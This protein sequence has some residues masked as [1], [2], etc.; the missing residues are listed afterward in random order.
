M[1]LI[2]RNLTILC[3]IFVRNY[4][5]PNALMPGSSLQ[6][7]KMNNWKL[8]TNPYLTAKKQ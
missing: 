1:T 6:E 2:G 3:H 8:Q 4:P 5:K 7:A